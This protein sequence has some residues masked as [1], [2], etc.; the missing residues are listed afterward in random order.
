[1]KAEEH[2]LINKTQVE[3]DFLARLGWF[4]RNDISEE[5]E[6]VIRLCDRHPDHD[7]GK[8]WCDYEDQDLLWTFVDALKLDVRSALEALIEQKRAEEKEHTREMI[9]RMNDLYGS[10]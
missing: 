8:A 1:M 10:K 5:I 3:K 7:F 9:E 2:E 4:Y 6:D